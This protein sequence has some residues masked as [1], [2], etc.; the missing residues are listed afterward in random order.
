MGRLT[1]K[2]DRKQKRLLVLGLH[3]ESGVRV[4]AARLHRLQK[5]LDRLAAFLGASTC[6]REIS[7]SQEAGSGE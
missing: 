1:P 4:T 2:M 5:A 3:W 6:Q 7:V